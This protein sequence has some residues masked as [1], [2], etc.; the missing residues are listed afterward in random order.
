MIGTSFMGPAEVETLLTLGADPDLRDG[1]GRNAALIAAKQGAWET[2]SVLID[3]GANFSTPD[4]SGN[5]ALLH[6][7]LQGSAE[8]ART[9]MDAGADVPDAATTRLYL[10]TGEGNSTEIDA[11]LS[12]EPSDEALNGALL[13][14]VRV[15]S[16]SSVSRLLAA[17]ADP[18]SMDEQGNPILFGA[19]LSDRMEVVDA[20]LSAGASLDARSSAD[21]TVPEVAAGSGSLSVMTMLLENGLDPNT[22]SEE[23]RTLLMRT[24]SAGSLSIAFLF[25]SADVLDRGAYYAERQDEFS[26]HAEVAKLL[27]DRG[28][29][30]NAADSFGG[31]TALI[32]AVMVGNGPVLRLL[33]E[34]GADLDHQN[35]VGRTALDQ[36]R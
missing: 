10:A 24:A 21:E 13:I 17:G 9:L 11:A 19:V 27:I 2:L 35:Q 23:G 22:S 25:G 29:D 26:G 1:D 31:T 5:T 6:A 8:M 36:A 7:L 34:T 30:V 33:I 3:A 16:D 18:D 14:A 20:L 28:A 32:D 4:G 15:E 12:D